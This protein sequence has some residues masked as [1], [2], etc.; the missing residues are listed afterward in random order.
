MSQA[1]A[2]LLDL[3]DLERRVPGRRVRREHPLE[4]GGARHDA[5]GEG[6]E[7]VEKLLF[8]GN[9]SKLEHGASMAQT[10]YGCVNWMSNCGRLPAR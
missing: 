4:Q 10:C 6:H 5:V 2:L 3:P 8:L 1:V 9:Q 7:I